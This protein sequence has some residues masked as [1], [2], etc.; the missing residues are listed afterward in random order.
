MCVNLD[1]KTKTEPLIIYVVNQY[2][3]KWFKLEN[4]KVMFSPTLWKFISKMPKQKKTVSKCNNEND[5]KMTMKKKMVWF[6][7]QK[8]L[9]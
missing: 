9:R 6:L 8:I 5:I 4:Q 1:A 3:F 7:N 2:R